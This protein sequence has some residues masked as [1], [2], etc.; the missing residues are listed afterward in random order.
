MRDRAVACV[1]QCVDSFAVPR[2]RHLHRRMNRACGD[3]NLSASWVASAT[4]AGWSLLPL[5]VGLQAPC[6]SQSSLQ[7][8]SSNAI[9]ANNQGIAAADD[10]VTRAGVFGVPPGSPIYLDLEGYAT[11][12]ASCTK[13]AQALRPGGTTSCVCAVS[14]PGSTAVPRRRSATS[15]LSVFQSL[16]TRGSRTGTATRASSAI[17]TSATA[18]GRTISAFTSSRA[19]TKRRGVA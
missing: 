16:T 8:I 19:A 11:N 13:I 1:A 18:S 10:A 3:G 7:K 4:A 5:Y 12:N 17:R 6:V 14:S 15:R 9:T 2:A